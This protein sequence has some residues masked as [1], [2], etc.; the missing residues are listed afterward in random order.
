MRRVAFGLALLLA[1]PLPAMTQTGGPNTISYQGTIA[2][3]AGNPVA[4]GNYALT[5]KIYDVSSGGAPIWTQ[6][7]SAVPVSG[8]GFS[9]LLG[10]GTGIALPFD[11]PYWISVTVG[12][13]TESTRTAF[14]ASPYAM[15]LRLPYAATAGVVGAP[16]ITIRNSLNP[17][18]LAVDGT[19]E[20]G[21]TRHGQLN[22]TGPGDSIV[23]ILG[24][25]AWGGSL[26]LSARSGASAASLFA[27]SNGEGTLELNTSSGA[28]GS[29]IGPKS[30]VWAGGSNGSVVLDVNQTGN[31]AVRLPSDVIADHEILDEPGLNSNT[32]QTSVSMDGT[33]AQSLNQRSG[34]MPD[35]GFVV[36]LST[37]RI[38]IGHTTGTSSNA[39]F[40]HRVVQNGVEH[41]GNTAVVVIPSSAPSGTYSQTIT[42]HDVFAALPGTMT[43][44]LTGQEV[45]GGFAVYHRRTTTMFMPTDYGVVEESAPQAMDPLDDSPPRRTGVMRIDDAEV[46]RE[47][48]RH[49][50]KLAREVDAMRRELETLR[51]RLDA[52]SAARVAAAPR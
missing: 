31:Q 19:V 49:E 8:G 50:S 20:F 28:S 41:V 40:T 30:A 36:V 2:D 48:A 52:E 18:G 9:V 5:F 14:A 3:A 39:N 35:S 33:L 27:K 32:S 45:T 44:S 6:T 42:L 23:A 51:R 43:T 13:G 29:V 26:S 16:L 11:K 21:G 47:R 10:S 38:N 15:S 1:S 22:I 24:S 34:T 37:F 4:D 25:I 7:Q 17:N 46:A 12:S